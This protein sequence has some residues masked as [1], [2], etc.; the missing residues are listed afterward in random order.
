M[1]HAYPTHDPVLTANA[2]P[3]RSPRA[4][5]PLEARIVAIVDAYGAAGV[6]VRL[7]RLGAYTAF[8]YTTWVCAAFTW[9]NTSAL[10]VRLS[11]CATAGLDDARMLGLCVCL[12]VWLLRAALWAGGSDLLVPRSLAELLDP[13]TSSIPRDAIDETATTE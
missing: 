13:V 2:K 6:I 12:A 8:D 5:H 1:Q 7:L 4:L 9:L 10:A 3:T 11:G